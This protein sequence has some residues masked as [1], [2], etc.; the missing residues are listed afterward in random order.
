M[1]SYI[2][3][4]ARARSISRSRCRQEPLIE[5]GADV[6]IER[7]LDHGCGQDVDLPAS[8]AMLGEISLR[9]AIAGFDLDAFAQAS[10]GERVHLC[11]CEPDARLRI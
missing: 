3:I 8:V 11:A 2:Y 9:S 10:I 1:L 5:P 6:C 4:S 7:L